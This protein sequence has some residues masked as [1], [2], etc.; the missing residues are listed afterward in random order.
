MPNHDA[1]RYDIRVAFFLNGRSDASALIELVHLLQKGHRQLFVS[2]V[3]SELRQSLGV[4]VCA[5][6]RAY[7]RLLMTIKCD[8]CRKP[9]FLNVRCYWRMRFCS[10][11][12]VK[13]YQH[14]L[15]EVTLGK[16]RYLEI[17]LGATAGNVR[18]EA[19]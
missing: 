9:L 12:C 17:Q 14:R 16:V 13:S 2:V 4:Y 8:H 15:N 10:A 11:D 18:K 19:A 7:G 6:E 3:R 5:R 1:I